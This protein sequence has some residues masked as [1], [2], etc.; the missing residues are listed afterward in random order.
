MMENVTRWK[1]V[2]II[3]FQPIVTAVIKFVIQGNIVKITPAQM[4][5]V[6]HQL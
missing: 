6:I 3:L 5:V 4:N 1:N 2:V